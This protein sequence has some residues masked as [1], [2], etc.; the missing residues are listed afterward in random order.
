MSVCAHVCMCALIV[1]MCVYL[2]TLGARVQRGLLYLVCVS[3]YVSVCVCVCLHLFSRYRD[4]AGSSAIPMAL[5]QQGLEKL[6]GDF[7]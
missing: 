6:C 3:V 7:A 5:A 2:L 1:C 4:Q